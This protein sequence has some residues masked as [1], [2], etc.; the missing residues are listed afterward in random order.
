M[1]S[2]GFSE[3]EAQSLLS[4][5][6][7]RGQCVVLLDGLDEITASRYNLTLAAVRRFVEDRT[8]ARPTLNARVIITC[9]RQNL[10]DIRDEW[11]GPIADQLYRIAPLRVSEINNY[12]NNLRS[13]FRTATGPEEFIAAVRRSGTFELHKTPLVLAMSVGLFA[14]KVQY[15]IPH[16]ISELYQNIVREMLDRHRFKGEDA[17]TR[18]RV[19]DKYRLLRAFA[20]HAAEG[21]IGFGEFRRTDLV[22]LAASM[23]RDLDAVRTS[24][25]DEFVEEIITRSGMVTDVT[26][27]AG[28]VFAHR[29]F[30]EYLVAEEFIRHGEEGAE[31]LLGHAVDPEW[32][33]VILFATSAYDQRLAGPLLSRLATQN[34]TLA[35]QCLAGADAPDEVAEE[36]IEALMT[37]IGAE[38]DALTPCLSAILASTGSPRTYVQELG[39]AKATLVLR[40]LVTLP[41]LRGRLGGDIEAVT[42]VIT[43]IASS[44]ATEIA[45]LVPHLARALPDD[46]LLVEPL[47]TCLATPGLADGP[48]GE[49]VARLLLLATDPESFDELQGQDPISRVFI[50][51]STRTAAYPFSRS[52]SRE[53]NLVTL[54][55]WARHLKLDLRTTNR[56]LE[57]SY[58]GDLGTVERSLSRTVS[59]R[60]VRALVAV[61]AL[62]QLGLIGAFL[63]TVIF[64]TD[65]IV[66]RGIGVLL[67]NILLG[68]VL[69]SLAFGPMVKPEHKAVPI[70]LSY[71]SRREWQAEGR[72][73]AWRYLLIGVFLAPTYLPGVLIIVA[74]SPLMSSGVVDYY[75]ISM[76]ASAAAGAMNVP[77]VNLG[78]KLY[79][80]RPNV[81]VDLYH[82]VRSQHWVAAAPAVA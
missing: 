71:R 49:I 8:Q 76:A 28:F 63:Y 67:A 13:K 7:K 57:A 20:L 64:R 69:S 4:R 60:P 51:D 72:L 50:T 27:D 12:L 37:R 68:I 23:S 17:A 10:A 29:S 52:L 15:E 21:E 80:R 62:L 77:T 3:L 5:I 40:D 16:S 26:D 42:R 56:F 39:T 73:P 43:T 74:L 44:N 24:D 61:F 36:I 79:L 32:K 31:R 34:L 66:E 82:D 25:V 70:S 2:A 58:T 19:K 75:L 59:V 30:Q 41:D 38:V 11:V 65:S 47:W 6:V 9:R 33:Q 22:E 45:A 48:A 54:L 55:A 14:R 46:P 35:G 81:F 78:F 1:R 18:F 53:S